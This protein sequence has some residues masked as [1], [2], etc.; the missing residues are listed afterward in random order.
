MP[1]VTFPSMAPVMMPMES[2]H[3]EPA[4]ERFAAAATATP[5]QG[6]FIPFGHSASALP[7]AVATPTIYSTSPYLESSLPAAAHVAQ[8]DPLAALSGLTDDEKIALFS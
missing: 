7:I 5:T 2:T 8:A 3:A 4:G 6:D 1:E